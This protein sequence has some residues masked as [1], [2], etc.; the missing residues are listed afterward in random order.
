MFYKDLH[1]RLYAIRVT[2]GSLESIIVKHHNLLLRSFNL[3]FR[4]NNRLPKTIAFKHV[5]QKK[6]D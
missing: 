4:E 1:A 6:S 3:V 5:C 2:V